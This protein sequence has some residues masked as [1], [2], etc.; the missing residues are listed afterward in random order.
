[1]P[2]K[3]SQST[4]SVMA[5]RKFKLSFSKKTTKVEMSAVSENVSSGSIASKRKNANF[6]LKPI[7]NLSINGSLN[8]IESM[9]S[10]EMPPQLHSKK[11]SLLRRSDE[12]KRKTRYHKTTRLLFIVSFS[13][14]LLNTP[15]YLCK[16]YYYLRQF[17]YNSETINNEHINANNTSFQ[18]FNFSQ[19]TSTQI[20][21]EELDANTRE[22]IMERITCF[23]YYLNFSLNFFLYSFCTKDFRRNF[24]KSFK[25]LCWK[26]LCCNFFSKGSKSSKPNTPNTTNLVIFNKDSVKEFDKN[27]I[28]G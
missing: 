4:Q 3:Q 10:L 27:I 5:I 2:V 11:G 28:R 20:Y 25:D 12:L 17:N 21:V 9:Q 26:C 24:C 22:E 13:F 16:L 18:R 6:T 1:M 23:L 14:C 8:L 15:M 7:K 19:N